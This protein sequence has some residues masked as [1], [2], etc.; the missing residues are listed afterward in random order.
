M[1]Y[2]TRLR[3]RLETELT[4][5]IIPF[6]EKYSIDRE[7]GGFI[8]CLERDGTPY[9]GQKQMWMQWREVYMFAVLF[10]SEFRQKRYLRY[11][12]DGFDF[13]LRH[14]RKSNGSYFYLLDRSGYP[15][16]D[17]GAGAEVFSESFGAIACAE[18]Y[19]ATSEKKYEDEA[20]SCLKI[21]REKTGKQEMISPEF[22]GRIPWKNLAY[23]MIELNVLCIMQKAFDNRISDHEIMECIE[24]IRSFCHPELG[25]IFERRNPDGCFDLTSQDGRFINPGHSL[26]GLSFIMEYERLHKNAS[27]EQWA[28]TASRRMI[29]YGWDESE[30]GVR[31]FCDV[32]NKP[33]VKN[34]NMLK[35]WWPQC[36][37]ST[38][39]L[40]AFELSG[41]E[42]FLDW[43]EK[44]EEFSH[45]HLRDPK[46][47]EWFAYA[48]IGGYQVHTY[49]GSCWKTFF[50]LPRYLLNCIEIC[51]RLE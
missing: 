5:N 33:I 23:P 51:R 4:G 11:A 3:K 26:E 18:L 44:I 41:G 39:M 47:P 46:Y 28:L 49:K 50:H 43:F 34:E 21:Y 14:G 8:S 32:L 9:D 1:N 38:A 29:Q 36:E 42:E 17:F 30:G 40:R 12:M 16:S 22:P 13:L 20:F 35:A 6:W 31:Y 7:Y 15:V 10:N 27:L 45:L 48:A 24:R 2:F 19:M 37:S 25:L